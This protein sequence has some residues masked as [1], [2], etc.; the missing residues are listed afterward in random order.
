M[1]WTTLKLKVKE[2]QLAGVS[3][4]QLVSTSTERTESESRRQ[5]N[6]WL[7]HQ[8]EGT[9]NAVQEAFNIRAESSY[10]PL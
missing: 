8:L 10:D 7:I 2:G 3:F 4:F 6:D 5:Q 9:D 1:K